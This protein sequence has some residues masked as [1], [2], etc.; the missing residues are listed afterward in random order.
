MSG[1]GKS[2]RSTSGIEAEIL[3]RSRVWSQVVTVRLSGC[4]RRARSISGG[5]SG[6]VFFTTISNVIS[7]A[8]VRAMIECKEMER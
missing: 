6:S 3:E 7:F 8:E 2:A 5:G 1:C 4:S